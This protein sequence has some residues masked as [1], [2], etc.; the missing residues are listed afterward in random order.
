MDWEGE[1]GIYLLKIKGSIFLS[2]IPPP[3]WNH[4]SQGEKLMYLKHLIF[5][6]TLLFQEWIQL[7]PQNPYHFQ[8]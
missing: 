4:P 7:L 8:I 2:S 3:I 6:T 1:K 5:Y